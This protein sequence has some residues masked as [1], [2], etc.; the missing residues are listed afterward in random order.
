LH[1]KITSLQP[2]IGD[3]QPGIEGLRHG[4]TSLHARIGDLQ[5]TVGRVSSHEEMSFLGV[6]DQSGGFSTR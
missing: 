2:R 3:L 6:A 1:A 5:T 4:I